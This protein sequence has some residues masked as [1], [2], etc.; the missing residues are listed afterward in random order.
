MKLYQITLPKMD[1]ETWTRLT[2][3]L[4][5]EL[6]ALP[7]EEASC[8]VKADAAAGMLE[9]HCEPVAERLPMAEVR[10]AAGAVLAEALAEVV[11]RVLESQLLSRIAAGV[12][13][14]SGREETAKLIRYSEELLEGGG[15]EGAGQTGLR[16][17]AK[18]AALI[19][20]YLQEQNALHLEGF[21]TFRLP[22]YRK[23]LE[24]TLDYAI[25]EMV[26]DQQYQD[27]ISLL[28][29]YVFIQD[30]IM[31]AAHLLHKGG[32]DFQLLNDQMKPIDPKLLAGAGGD[33]PDTGG[34]VEDMI[35]SAL[36]TVSPRKIFIHT[37]EPEL[38]VIKTIQQ[39]FEN[40]VELCT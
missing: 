4:T 36:L 6:R 25:E 30:T 8:R 9:L 7:H 13:P 21:V 1:E 40:R 34:T 18:I 19:A 16:R 39:I 24:E 29:Y 23:E 32:H 33:M 28:K 17:R 26:M 11:V 10:R 15:E 35:V 14:F 5:R 12:S 20:D 38:Q 37:R 2:E 27:F 22:F 3:E 31:P